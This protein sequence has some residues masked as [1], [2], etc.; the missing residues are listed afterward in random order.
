MVEEGA[1]P[2]EGAARTQSPREQ[3]FEG[4][5]P[6]GPPM[7]TSKEPVTFRDV[8]VDFTPEE[9]G[10]LG[11]AQRRLYRDVML[12]TYRNLVSL[13]LSMP[14]PAAISLL[15]REEPWMADVE[16]LSGPHSDGRTRPESSASAPGW[17][18]SEEGMSQGLRTGR[19]AQDGPWS[20][21]FGESQACEGWLKE[22]RG[23][24]TGADKQVQSG[25][26]GPEW[27]PCEK[28]LC[29]S[30]LLILHQSLSLAPQCEA[31]GK[32]FR[33]LS[34][35]MERQLVRAEKA[36]GRYHCGEDLGH[37]AAGAGQPRGKPHKC[38]ECGKAFGQSALLTKHLRVHTGDKPYECG[39]CGKAFNQTS[40]LRQ[41]RRIHNEEKP[42]GC[43]ECGKAFRVSSSLTEHWR[44]HTGEKPYQ[45]NECGKAF[46]RSTH[47][48]QH[49]RIHTG[50]KPF[51]CGECGKAFNRSTL[52]TQ[53]QR[54]HTGKKPYECDECGKA[55][56]VS[57]SLTEHRRIHTG[58]KPYACHECGKAFNC[59]KL[60]TQHQRIHTGE[61][62]YECG[63]CGK[64]FNKSPN[65][66]RHQR[67]HTGEKPYVC[68][69]C[70]KTFNQSTHLIQHQRIH[71]GEVFC[72]PGASTYV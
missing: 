6:T 1:L 27:G 52:L 51:A 49:Q 54:I 14:T 59:S 29:L 58:E 41:H 10:R 64:A 57:S 43:H 12:E 70:G 62:P 2:S 13:G 61:K 8:A 71:T 30:P 47:L 39:D 17:D 42:F 65:L 15:E 38:R 68:R 19:S 48:T 60:L 69:D 21:R 20:P 67:I 4:M 11:P 37:G 22:H 9:W 18:V 16:A 50:E 23:Q 31:R 53:H 36:P 7:A 44:T 66:T 46:N 72:D 26:L 35:L 28:S 56:R 55:F 5:A 34:P 33:Q 32:S 40:H 25:A 63:Q 45:C 3:E 24:K